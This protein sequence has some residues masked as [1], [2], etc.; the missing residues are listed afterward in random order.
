M[1]QLGNPVEIR[2]PRR[3]G[4]LCEHD[5]G[6]SRA[7]GDGSRCDR[8]A[9]V[10]DSCRS[11]DSYRPTGPDRARGEGTVIGVGMVGT[12][13]WANMIQ[14]PVLGQVPDF[15]V[16]GVLSRDPENAR[17]TAARFGIPTAYETLEQLVSDP[18]V[19]LVNI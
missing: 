18:A 10:G 13:F 15:Q 3:S 11:V 2:I 9:T 8:G 14:L 17:K 7:S 16:I 12:G 1:E 19:Q 5:F 6:K 4:T